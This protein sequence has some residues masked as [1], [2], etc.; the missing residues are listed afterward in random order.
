MPGHRVNR[1]GLGHE[2]RTQKNDRCEV[3]ASQRP[4]ISV[5]RQAYVDTP[6]IIQKV[7]KDKVVKT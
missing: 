1:T 6:N 7:K 2:R 4:D 3:A 5:R